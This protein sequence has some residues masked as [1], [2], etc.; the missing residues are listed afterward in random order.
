LS[1]VLALVLGVAARHG[2]LMKLEEWTVGGRGFG[3]V[4]VFLLLA[5][6]IY[7]TF[8]FLG[9]SGWAYALG[10]PAYYI[11]AYGTLAYIVSYFMLLRI[12]IYARRHRLVSQPDFYALKFASPALGVLVALVGIMALVPYLVLQFTGLGVI[13]DAASYG[14]IPKAVSVIIGAIVVT[15]YVIVSGIRGSAWTAVVK[16]TLIVLVAIFLGLY[17]PMHYQG[18]ITAMFSAIDKARP[19]FLAFAPVGKSLAWFVSTVLLTAF[20][21]FM[22]PHSFASCY[23]ARHAD[24]FR[25]DAIVLPLYQL[26]L[27][28]IF[29]VGFSAMLVIPGL[30]G[31]ATNMALLKIVVA[32]F[33]PWFVGVVGATGVLTALVPGS[34]IMMMASTLFARNLVAVL[35]PGQGDDTTV[36]IAKIG[37]PAVAVIA[38]Y[39]AIAGSAT[40]VALLLMGYSFVTQLLPALICSLMPR[41]PATKEGAMAGI[42]VGVGTVVY[43]T[44][45][46]ATIATLLPGFPEFVRDLNVGTAA[47]LLNILA[48]LVV[49]GLTATRRM[50]WRAALRNRLAAVLAE[51]R[52]QRIGTRVIGHHLYHDLRTVI[53]LPVVG[54]VGCRVRGEYGPFDRDTGI[55]PARAGEGDDIRPH[56]RRRR[57][58]DAR[59]HRRKGKRGI[60]ADLEMISHDGAERAVVH[61]HDH[62]LRILYTDLGAKA[63]AADRVE[64]GVRPR[65]AG[66]ARHE[67]AASAGAAQHEA[68]LKDLRADHD[69]ARTPQRIDDVPRLRAI[70]DFLQGEG[71][72]INNILLGGRSRPAVAI[73]AA[74][75]QR[76]QGQQTGHEGGVSEPHDGLSSFSLSRGSALGEP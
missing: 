7:T 45:T 5:G 13:V 42:V 25:K 47:L 28:F 41:N 21:F 75:G 74:A 76:Q 10:A 39:F 14:A 20:G 15:L 72:T 6:E 63:A 38:A 3:A 61:D 31:A 54:N 33:P 69:R 30:K 26:V 66:G 8:T 32:A 18:G 70:Q 51:R 11:L 34:M 50:P 36:L 48:L 27:L 1:A 58:A 73:C 4:L 60:T 19:G 59:T 17:L 2:H 9:A 53:G 65:P 55:E 23:T 40:I 24:V 56:R 49:S 62:D 12:W 52:P 16:D 71:R 67:H 22:W 43:L 46:N 64:G 35:R 57:T 29:F 68:G 37:V 44:L